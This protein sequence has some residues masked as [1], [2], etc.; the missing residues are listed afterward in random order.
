[1][2]HL[3]PGLRSWHNGEC[4]RCMSPANV[5]Y[6]RHTAERCY[7][8]RSLGSEARQGEAWWHDKCGGGFCQ[9][10]VTLCICMIAEVQEP[11]GSEEM[12]SKWP[13]SSLLMRPDVVSDYTLYLIHKL[14]HCRWNK[15]DFAHHHRRSEGW[16]L[17]AARTYLLEIELC[18]VLNVL[19]CIALVTESQSAGVTTNRGPSIG[20]QY[21]IKCDDKM[22]R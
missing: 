16:L 21:C 5:H 22:T 10:W 18:I 11:E 14:P 1:M 4:E 17:A 13:L 9:H 3:C 20:F 7:T 8:F 6:C 12:T 19:Y 15:L 2:S